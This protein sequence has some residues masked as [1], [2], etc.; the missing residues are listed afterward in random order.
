MSDNLKLLLENIGWISTV[1]PIYHLEF[2]KRSILVRTLIEIIN[3]LPDLDS[4]KILSVSI[5]KAKRL[6]KKEKEFIDDV[7][8]YNKIT[9][10]YVEN[11]IKVKEIVPLLDLSPWR[12]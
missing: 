11:M 1:T 5:V 8:N 3:Y 6:T 10:V 7:R 4:L 9:K 2:C 12:K